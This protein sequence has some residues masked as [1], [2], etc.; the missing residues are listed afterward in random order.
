MKRIKIDGMLM[1]TFLTTLFYA[2]TYP[3]IHKQ[4]DSC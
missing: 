2:S 3:Y 4:N 1:A